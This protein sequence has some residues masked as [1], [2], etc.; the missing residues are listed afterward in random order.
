LAATTNGH[1]PNVSDIVYTL[2]LNFLSFCF[3]SSRSREGVGTVLLFN[4]QERN[5]YAF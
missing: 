5:P 4:S 1:A 2:H 3:Y